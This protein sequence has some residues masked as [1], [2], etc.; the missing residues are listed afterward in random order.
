MCYATHLVAFL[1]QSEARGQL[2]TG[3]ASGNRT[4]RDGR[5]AARC[6]PGTD[7]ASGNRTR[8]TTQGHPPRPITWR[9]LPLDGDDLDVEVEILAGKLVV[10]VEREAVGILG[11]HRHRDGLPAGAG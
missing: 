10:G 3:G 9:R 6:Q 2:G 8:R 1:V 4:G 7:D 11:G 5:G